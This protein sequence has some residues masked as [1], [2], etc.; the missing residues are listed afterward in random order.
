MV[1]DVIVELA[2]VFIDKTFTYKVPDS[3]TYLKVGMRVRVPFGKQELEGFVLK[4]YFSE[5]E[6]LKDIIS[7]VDT[8]PVL[9]DELIELGRYVKDTTL[10]SLM[11]AYQSMLPLALKAKNK[12]NLNKKYDKYIRLNL[13]ID[14]SGFK[15]NEKQS[16]IIELLKKDEIIKKEYL[17]I[18]SSSSVKTLIGKNILLLEEREVYRLKYENKEN[19]S[20]NLNDEQGNVYEKII[21]NLGVSKTFLLYGI[22]GS[23]KTNVYMKVIEKVIN[24]GKTAIVL[25]PEI[26]LT[27]QIISRFTSNFKSIA[28]LHSGLSDGEKYDEWR[29]IREGKVNI[30]V[31][32]RSAIFAP[33]DNVGVI[34]I[35]EEHSTT[36]KQDNNPRYNA[37][38]IAKWRSKYNNC[39][40]ILGS[41][42]P[43]IDDFARAKK[44]VYELLTLNKRYNNMLPDIKIVD[45]NKEF[46]KS[47]GYLSNT[48][49]KEIQ[50]K[51]SN[52]EQIILFLNRRGYSSTVTCKSCGYTEKCP[53]CDISLTYHKTSNMLRCHYCGYAKKKDV[54]CP[55]CHEDFKEFGIGTEKLEEEINKQIEGAK[56]IRMDVDT[57]TKRGAHERIITDF[58][59][60]KANI[61]LGTQMISKGLDFPNVTLVGVVNAD[62]SLNFPD[63]RASEETFELLNQVSGRSGRGDK[64]GL[65]FI[66]TFNPDHYA[67][68]YSVNNDYLGFYEEE[69]KI[70]RKFSY[71]PYYYICLIKVS[72]LSYDDASSYAVRI[73]KYLRE[74][75]NKAI[76]LGP[77]VCNIFKLNNRY[78][79]QIIIKYKDINDVK[80]AI[81]SISEH[82]FND[83]KIKLE[84]DFN[85]LKL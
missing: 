75:I 13:D 46:K 59:E 38:D 14:I 55:N 9:N 27:P 8:Y 84:I 57:T 49:I 43:L 70:R 23:G 31:G 1:C 64:K 77:S 10:C 30:V 18:I 36:Y 58:G 79:F 44:G 37:I 51:I 26:S 40:L 28:V 66:Q 50:N 33:F 2:H 24:E 82:Y 41:A 85:P 6:D 61:L 78:R 34:I 68:K 74:N 52:D 20:F 16:K 5:M 22:T 76:I 65:V 73:G 63:F 12:V 81:Q 53:N 62:I 29:K 3:F 48:L 15:F 42:T 47:N 32:A 80:D 54:K 17:D 45:M 7:V 71:P 35:D 11:C 19:T 72:S 60:G 69:M 56:V 39:P 83:K 25:V 4:I 21:S 67:I